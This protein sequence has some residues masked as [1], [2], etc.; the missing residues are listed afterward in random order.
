M[1]KTQNDDSP[2]MEKE[3]H[4]QEWGVGLGQQASKRDLD[5]SSADAS[6]DGM[7]TGAGLG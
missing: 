1:V 4:W 6:Q 7:Q 5:P 3:G 2:R